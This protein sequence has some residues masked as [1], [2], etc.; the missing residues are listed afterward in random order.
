MNPYFFLFEVEPQPGNPVGGH[1]S[2]AIVHIWVLSKDI[3]E[4]RQTVLRF[5]KTELWDVKEEKQAFLPT[6]EQVAE[7]DA[8]AASSY[9]RAQSEGIHATFNYWHR[10]E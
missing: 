6:P 10:T 2:R 5:F 4:A 1:A 9:G 3:E 7:L 8:E